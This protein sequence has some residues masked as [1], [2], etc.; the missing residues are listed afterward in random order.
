MA[1]SESL[2][3]QISALPT[4]NRVVLYIK[5]TRRMPR[6]GFPAQVVRILDALLPSYETVDVL[7]PGR[8]N[9]TSR[10]TGVRT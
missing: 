8:R 2:R 3:Q 6:C 10:T 1:L 9:T 7:R 5:G 4:S